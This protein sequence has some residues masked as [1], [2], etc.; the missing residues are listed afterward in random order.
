[1]YDDL[2]VKHSVILPLFEPEFEDLSRSVKAEYD[3]LDEMDRVFY[4]L[5]RVIT[6]LGIE[7]V[8]V[9]SENGSIFIE[10]FR[11]DYSLEG[12]VQ[13]AMFDMF[14]IQSNIINID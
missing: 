14:Q 9:F 1:M 10:F 3:S 12:A 4:V 5:E 7:D 13:S 2:M 6:D 11:E 8:E